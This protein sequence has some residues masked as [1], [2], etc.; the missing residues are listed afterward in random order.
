MAI[1]EDVIAEIR[2]RADIVGIIGQYVHLR[3][4]GKNYVG[5]CPFHH[6]KTPSF[7]VSPELGIYKCFGCGKSGD[8]FTFLQEYA[9]MSFLEAV[10]SIAQQMGIPI[11]D[12]DR[13]SRAIIEQQRLLT[14]AL[15][16]ARDLFRQWA[17]TSPPATQF[18][19]DRAIPPAMIER[20]QL[21]Y[22]PASWTM[23]ADTLIQR[24]FSVDL[25]HRT[26]LIVLR[27]DG[28]YYDRFR[29]RIMFPI[30][31]L[32]GNVI[33]FGGRA[34]ATD[35]DEPKYINSPQTPLYDKS[36]VLYALHFAKQAIVRQ[37]YA[38]V[39]EGYMD[40]IALHS[41]GIE[42]SVATSGTA[43]TTQ[44]LGVLRRFT[45][46]VVL[47]YDGDDAG[48]DAAQ[49]AVRMCLREGFAADVV[50]MP[51]GD[52]PDSVVRRHGGDAMRRLLTERRSAIDFLV[53]WSKQRFDWSNQ[54]IATTQIRQL[55]ET[56]ASV[57]DALYRELL[58]RELSDRVGIR[59]EL[60]MWSGAPSPPPSRVQK[61]RPIPREATPITLPSP[62][63][64][65]YPEEAA[66]LKAVLFS[67][68]V[69]KLLLDDYLFEPSSLITQPA[70]Q[71]LAALADFLQTDNT[72]T[73]PG[74]ALPRLDLSGETR[75]LAE[76]LIFTHESPSHR[77]SDDEDD[78]DRIHRALLDDAIMR[79][80]ERR[81]EQRISTLNKQ[82]EQEPNNLELLQ[83]IERLHKLRV[84]LRSRTA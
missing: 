54:R 49:R 2:K 6:E 28:K 39:V 61:K 14:T 3:Q 35:A 5:L 75:Q 43:L 72:D 8:V 58:L 80:E 57:P 78:A 63:L 23:L 79:L 66:L 68:K 44:H 13:R 17:Q 84:Q 29:N 65:I 4:R 40:A 37:R 56:V 7:N 76:W 15:A 9:G 22:A 36:S 38:I 62:P 82:L 60:L 32:S 70:Q 83:Q 10:H 30:C 12:D 16:V 1:P 73:P 21:G 42:H 71:L 24:G 69:A 46:H 27:D 53:S 81:L 51:Q 11:P 33:A 45:E 74:Q 64:A 48:L 31:D 18:F 41:N 19:R 55:A 50:L 47:L 34:L 59:Q 52:D 26:G 25:L 67:R 20:F 77:W